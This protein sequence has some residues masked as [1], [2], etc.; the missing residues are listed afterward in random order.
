MPPL[1][2]DSPRWKLLKAHFGN[3]GED[4][5]LPAVPKLLVRWRGAI[6]RYSEEYE[7]APLHESFLHQGT[8]LDVAYA[9]VPHLAAR[10]G[11]LPPD[12]RLDVL[13]DIADVE[14]VR[15][16]PRAEVERRVAAMQTMSEGLRDLFMQTTRDRHPEL[17]DDLAGAWFEAL[18]LAQASAAALLRE[19]SDESDFR[20][21]LEALCELHGQPKLAGV[22]RNLDEPETLVSIAKQ[23]ESV[24]KAPPR[25]WR[26]HVAH[27]R[28][29]GW[30]DDDVAFGVAI[31]TREN[32]DGVALIYGEPVRSVE[33]LRGLSDSD[34]P[35]GWA[36]RT[37]LGEAHGALA[38]SALRAIA[39]VRGV[40][41]A[42][43]LAP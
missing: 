37:R 22:F 35:P 43:M 15:R 38:V 29:L 30:T 32:E 16:V 3:A 41:L 17:P 42:T 20:L 24:G 12:R 2:L 18:A 19:V 10:L 11:D 9:V 4:A 6:G 21:L 25:N 27:L 5:D 1:P 31:L 8:I 14:A 40:G 13:A 28:E 34:A 36:S 39:W 23:C 26:R 33:A 7:Y